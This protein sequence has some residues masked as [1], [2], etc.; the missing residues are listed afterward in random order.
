MSQVTDTDEEREREIE[1]TLK[2]ARVVAKE[3]HVLNAIIEQSYTYT[4]ETGDGWNNTGS[5]DAIAIADSFMEYVKIRR[6]DV[7]FASFNVA[8]M[9]VF[10]DAAKR[11]PWQIREGLTEED[12]CALVLSMWGEAAPAPSPDPEAT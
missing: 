4:Q 9:A 5:D 6:A 7:D 11:T 8:A 1:I 10:F 12:I 2:A 3:L